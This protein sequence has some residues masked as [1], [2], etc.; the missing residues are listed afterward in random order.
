MRAVR[1][2]VDELAVARSARDLGALER[3]DRRVVG[4][5]RRDV[6]DR[7][8]RDREAG[9]TSAEEVDES[10]HL[11]HLRHDVILPC[12]G[13]AAGI[14][15][16]APARAAASAHRS[17]RSPAIQPSSRPRGP[18]SPW[19]RSPS[20]RNPSVRAARADATFPTT[21]RHSTPLRSSLPDERE[22]DHGARRLGEVPAPARGA[23]I[24]YP[25]SAEPPRSTRCRPIIPTHL[26][27]ARMPQ[28]S[29]V[30]VSHHPPPSR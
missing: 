23:A 29:S 11:G 13:D 27:S 28:V 8:P 24:Q 25:I 1:R 4:L 20:Y 3:V 9:H 18:S 7:D 14:S 2:Q 30:P 19:R 22:V 26:S 21:A 12:G 16:R 5:Q 15:P 17:T 10:L 6:R